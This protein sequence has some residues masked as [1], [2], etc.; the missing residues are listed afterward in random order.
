MRRVI[1][2]LTLILAFF[3]LVSSC[4]S[5]D[6]VLGGEML[7]YSFCLVDD[8]YTLA[9][10][11]II[12]KHKA[13]SIS[14]ISADCE[15]ADAIIIEQLEFDKEELHQYMGYYVYFLLLKLENNINGTPASTQIDGL[16]LDID[17]KEYYYETPAFRVINVQ[18][19]QQEGLTTSAGEILHSNAPL[20]FS[21]IPTAERPMNY[22]YIINEDVNIISLTPLDY[23]EIKDLSIDGVSIQDSDSIMVSATAGSEL[24]VSY[25]LDYI[26]PVDKTNIV[27]TSKLLTFSHGGATKVFVSTSG[28]Y[29][30]PGFETYKVINN[31]IDSLQ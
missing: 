21:H 13:D 25:Y 15:D 27:R 9:S 11:P 14:M 3:L 17:G 19:L 29:I 20:L 23:L 26:P 22:Y 8:S 24:Q 30:F 31:F 7:K 1:A 5:N 4:S 12:L 16:Y 10:C 28:Y 2:V 6:E 18:H